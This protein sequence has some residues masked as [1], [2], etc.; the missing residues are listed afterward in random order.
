MTNVLTIANNKG[1]VG[2]TTAVQVTAAYFSK[3]GKR[4]LLVDADPQCNLTSAMI[5]I[6]Y[7]EEGIDYLPTHP[8][9]SGMRFDIANIFLEED[10]AP[11]P[12][13]LP[14]VDI[15]P[16]K[17]SNIE[18]DKQ[19]SSL[20]DLFVDFLHQEG[21]S[22]GYDIVI[23]DTPPAKGL[24][25]SA[26]IRSATHVLIP[27]VLERKSVEGLLGM[28][29]KISTE[30]ECK[31]ASQKTKI[32]GILPNKVDARYRIHKEYLKQLNDS[33]GMA[34]IANLM[35]PGSIL[36][37]GPFLKSFV[38]KERPAL[39]EMEL[40]DASPTTPFALAKSTDIHKEWNALGQYVAQEMGLC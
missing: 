6:N 14:N 21:V 25:T 32:L 12:T 19:S 1:G 27:V 20:A 16:C 22:E 15:I 5:D 10:I 4:V 26:A 11:Y 35:I 29:S 28:I 39:K 23:I 30:N 36:D 37:Q 8:E 3:E 7:G 2:K 31:D 9:E 18:L 17:P 24:L 13:R 40:R 34:A 38:I 33:D